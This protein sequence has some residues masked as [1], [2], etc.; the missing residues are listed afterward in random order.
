MQQDE[1]QKQDQY[2]H[3]APGAGSRKKILIVDD[4]QEIT[5]FLQQALTPQY[6]TLTAHDGKQGETLSL[7]YQP[8]LIIVD[9][10]MPVMNGLEMSKRLKKQVKTA[11]IPI[12]LLTAK[13]DK[14]TELDSI[15]LGADAFMSKPFDISILLSRIEQ[16]LK[17][18]EDLENQ[19]RISALTNPSEEN[20]LSRDEQ[21]LSD[22][23][24]IIEEKM[25]DPQFNV[26][27]LSELSFTNPKQLYR[28]I[29]QLT[30]LTPVEYIRSIRM[31]KAAFLLQKNKFSV[32]E[33]MYMVGFSE[34]SYFS[35]C[36]Q[37]EFGQTPSQFI[38]NNS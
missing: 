19:L 37:A 30:S 3:P 21:F 6:H 38:K 14:K 20:P 26:Q 1:D 35:K 13:D 4:N 34:A 16:L 9:V 33:V 23:T 8:D 12:I 36:F 32:A 27:V 15:D 31:K 5:E 7:E 24:Q 2:Q 18:K 17:R 11:T 22:I 25:D 10:M 29:K 28:K